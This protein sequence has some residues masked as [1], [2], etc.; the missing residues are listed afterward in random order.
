MFNIKDVLACVAAIVMIAALAVDPFMQQIIDYHLRSVPI[1]E[2]TGA[3]TPSTQM[4]DSGTLMDATRAKSIF[5][6]VD[7]QSAIVNGIL[8]ISLTPTFHCS[9]GN[10]T[11]PDITKLGV[12]ASCTNVTTETGK[13]CGSRDPSSSTQTCQYT[14]PAN[15]N[16]TATNGLGANG[17]Y[18]YLNTSVDTV[19]TEDNQPLLRFGIL[20]SPPTENVDKDGVLPPDIS[21][22]TFEWCAQKTSGFRVHSGVLQPGNTTST[23]IKIAFTN[24]QWTPHTLN[25]RTYVEL[26]VAP[27]AA[28]WDGGSS[29]SSRAFYV[30]S[31]D[32]SSTRQLLVN[33]L[34]TQLASFNADADAG[35]GFQVAP[36]LLFAGGDLS[37]T[38]GAVAASMTD[39]VQ[40]CANGSAVRGQAFRDEAFVRVRWPW[41]VLPAVLVLVAAA[42]LQAA[43]VVNRRRGSALWK[44]SVLPLLFHGFERPLDAPLGERLSR[45]EARAWGMETSLRESSEG[46]S[47]FVI[48]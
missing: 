14:T 45:V 9:T 43:V 13:S 12:C 5:A 7:M 22:C 39:L 32:Y 31:A 41:L 23:P 48:H 27:D 42:L 34:V 21:E 4:Y 30:H 17:T 25:G 6:G 19:F 15:I 38:M 36:V 26:D 16:I 35:G 18:T 37:R 33:L 44:S 2:I 47:R 8:G 46:A 10:C 40:R 1:A 11:W 28:P 3:T 24:G 20:R 29:S